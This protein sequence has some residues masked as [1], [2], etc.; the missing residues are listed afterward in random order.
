MAEIDMIRTTEEISDISIKAAFEEWRDRIPRLEALDRAYRTGQDGDETEYAI[1]KCKYIA[2]TK[3]SYTCAIPPSYDTDQD[4]EAA[5]RIVEVYKDQI[6]EQT[7]QTL[8]AYCSRYGRA[9]ELVYM[10]VKD[11]VLVPDSEAISPLDAFVAYDSRL[12]PDSVFGAVHYT[13]EKPDGTK[14]HYLDVYDRSD[15]TTWTMSD[16][17]SLSW[18]KGES[19]PHGFE[20]VP[21]IE[22]RNNSEALGDFEA[23]LP[24]QK[25]INRVLTDRVQDKDR[26]AGAYLIS[27]GFWLGDDDEE[28]SESITKLKDQR[29]IGLPKDADLSYLTK[30]F[31]ESSVQVLVDDLTSELHTISQIPDLSDENFAANASGVAMRY[32]LLGLSNL[33]EAFLMQHRKG[34]IRRC[35]LYSTGLFGRPDAVD[36]SRM[37]CVFRFNLPSDEAYEA[38]ALQQYLSMGIL[39]RRTAMQICPYV[40][41][42]AQEEARIEEELQADAERTMRAGDDLIQRDAMIMLGEEAEAEDDGDEEL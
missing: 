28:V 40:E 1:N 14:V 29:V 15:K 7:D 35:K 37:R 21:L 16:A 3:T 10:D 6:K 31:D 17:G 27:K 4:D 32:K 8:T 5:E 34:F 2:D 11:G 25:A 23:V 9:F 12:K 38:Q 22:Y 33:C 18:V 30:S 26:F 36:I 24:I 20:R 19:V 13:K 41:D 39:S 42:V